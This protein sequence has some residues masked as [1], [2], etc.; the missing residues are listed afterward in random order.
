VQS[1]SFTVLACADEEVLGK[2]LEEGRISF[3]VSERFYKE[4]KV[5]RQEL[6]KL[7][8]QADNINLVGEKAVG[9]ALEE[10]YIKEADVIRVKGVPHAQIF[11]V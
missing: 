7:L 3:K 1:D 6:K 9:V 11:K 10:G 8:R 5:S 2:T 4:R